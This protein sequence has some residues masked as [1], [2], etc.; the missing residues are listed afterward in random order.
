MVKKDDKHDA[1]ETGNQTDPF[2]EES[3][4]NFTNNF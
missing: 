1:F 4:S 3:K 2:C